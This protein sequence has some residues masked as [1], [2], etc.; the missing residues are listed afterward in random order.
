M[1]KSKSRKVEKGK[2]DWQWVDMVGGPLKEVGYL[3]VRC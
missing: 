2:Q 1:E 3:P